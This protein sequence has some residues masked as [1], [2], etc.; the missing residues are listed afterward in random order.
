[1][2]LR[3][4]L[5]KFEAPQKANLISTWTQEEEQE[6]KLT[7]QDGGAPENSQKT[8]KPK[9]KPKNTHLKPRIVNSQLHIKLPGY[10]GTQKISLSDLIA[11]LPANRLKR[12]AKRQLLASGVKGSSKKKRKLKKRPP[13]SLFNDG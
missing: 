12:A 1:M 6:E 7:K 5:V 11:Y 4:P 9:A 13:T 10:K 2:F 8:Q 3:K